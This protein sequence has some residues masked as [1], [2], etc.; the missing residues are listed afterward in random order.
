MAKA[1]N[2]RRGSMQFWPRKRSKHNFVRVRSWANESK[3]KPLG[4]IA[5]KAGM[6]HIMVVDNRAKSSTKGEKIALPV[7]IFDC[8]A[9]FVIGASFY[10]KY[11]TGIRKQASLLYSELSKD[12]KKVIS[13]SLTVPKKYT[14]TIDSI[15]EFDSVRLIVASNPAKTTTGAKKPQIMEVAIGGS[16]D[17]QLGFVKEHLGKELLLDSVF[18][19]GSVVDAHGVTKGKGFQGVVKRYGVSTVSHK[20]EKGTRKVANMGA[21]TPKRVDYRVAQPGKMGYH[22]RTEYNKQIILQGNETD[23]VNKLGGLPHYGLVKNHFVLLKGT[24]AGPVKAPV[25]LTHAIRRTKNSKIFSQAPEVT[26]ISI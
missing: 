10:K 26:F 9:M 7:T 6:T 5:F 8:P 23:K 14:H 11:E 25:L 16:K 4:F 22:Q 20:S 21:W 12:M 3:A 17:D 24:V 1:H 18:E 19:N 13:R 2:P 15:T